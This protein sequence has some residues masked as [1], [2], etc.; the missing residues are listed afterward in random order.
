MIDWLDGYEHQ[1][2]T[3]AGLP[4]GP[5]RD[6]I[7]LHTTETAAPSLQTLVASWR[8]NW[9]AGLPH[10]IAEGGRY[11]Q[12]LPLTVNAYTMENKAGGADVNKAGHV[13][14]VEIVGYAR[15]ELT[16]Q[17]Y[18]ALG[19]WVGDLI[20][21]GLDINLDACPH[22]YGAN[23]GIVLASYSSPI[24]LGARAWT[25]AN[26]ILGHQHAPENCVTVDT[27]VL[28]SDLSWQPAVDFVPG[29]ELIGFDEHLVQVGATGGRRLRPSTVEAN[30]PFRAE[31][32]RV[33][34]A[35]GELVT[36][37][38]HPWLVRL[39][40]VNRGSRTTWVA[41]E[42]L[43]PA[44]HEVYFSA[45]P[46]HPERAHDAGWLAGA[47]DAD[48]HVQVN[49][50]AGCW[51]GWGQVEGPM[52]NRFVAEMESRGFTIKQFSRGIH[53]GYGAGNKQPFTDVR[54]LGGIWEQ[55]RCLGV[56]RPH[57]LDLRKAWDGAVVGKTTRRVP[58]LA[59]EPAG[60]R[61]MTGLQTSARTYIA[62]GFLVHNS[63]WDPGHI[64][65]ERVCR[66][67]CTV[68]N[69][70]ADD[71][72]TQEDWDRMQRIVEA[73]VARGIE[74]SVNIEGNLAGVSREEGGL[75]RTAGVADGDVTRQLITDLD[76]GSLV[77]LEAVQGNLAGV[78]EEFKQ[79]GA[80]SG[81]F[82]V[83]T[84]A[85]RVAASLDVVVKPPPP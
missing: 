30:L 8:R 68:T 49:R 76:H 4:V 20:N 56:L 35:A 45:E 9:G 17:E 66:I 42:H 84:V 71:M 34:T 75:T 65:I 31:A 79:A 12:L 58:V 52:L 1:P 15:N 67:A 81:D 72:W 41:S 48:G 7:V 44:E 54:V 27:P 5:G 39:P 73:G 10:F 61:W 74:A 83:A 63:H 24:R 19:R 32:V 22:F 78:L 70:E 37:R 25:E 64:D 53:R 55:L 21:A 23:D 59:V 60:H 57:R 16:D 47:L 69:Q 13:I 82:D 28:G 62:N 51:V 85:E 2:V 3:G 6:K 18:G 43:D 29:D 38:N 50:D 40:Y 80:L 26:G 11:V 36:T 14:Q 46:W 33:V 77:R